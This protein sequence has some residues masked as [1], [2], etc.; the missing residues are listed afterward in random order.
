GEK[1][2]TRRVVRIPADLHADPTLQPTP[3]GLDLY[4]PEY[5]EEGVVGFPNPYG[6][7][8]DRLWVREAFQV[9]TGYGDDFAVRTPIPP[10]NES[11]RCSVRY[12]AT[13]L[14]ANDHRDDRGFA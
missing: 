3:D 10:S 1:T 12:R 6:K 4:D 14:E 8:G 11:G 13:D 9:L 5:P 7:P 2:Q